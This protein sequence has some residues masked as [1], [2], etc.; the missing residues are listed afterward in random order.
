MAANRHALPPE[1]EGTPPI[2]PVLHCIWTEDELRVIYPLL[3][4]F[5]DADWTLQSVYGDTVQMMNHI[6]TVELI[7]MK[8]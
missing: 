4:Q 6:F 8:I 5:T 1:P 3:H 7:E 2:E